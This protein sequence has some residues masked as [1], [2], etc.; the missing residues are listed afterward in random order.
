MTAFNVGEVELVGLARARDRDLAALKVCGQ[1]VGDLLIKHQRTPVRWIGQG[2]DQPTRY[3]RCDQAANSAITSESLAKA[4]AQ[5]ITHETSVCNVSVAPSGCSERRTHSRIMLMWHWSIDLDGRNRRVHGLAI[6]HAQHGRPSS[7][8]TQRQ[9]SALR[10]I[11]CRVGMA[12]E[13]NASGLRSVRW[14]P[15]HAACS[16]PA[17]TSSSMAVDTHSC[18]PQ[19]QSRST[20]GNPEVPS[21][22]EAH[23]TRSAIGWSSGSPA[24]LTSRWRCLP[25]SRVKSA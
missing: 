25:P 22:I 10:P 21:L 7:I 12:A 13:C 23:T 8:A 14:H 18:L 5:G 19:P 11:R 9:A 3:A 6:D 15:R 2:H 20:A 17:S 24:G 4:Q 16:V 1:Q